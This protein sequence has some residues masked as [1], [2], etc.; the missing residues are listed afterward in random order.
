ME[1][2]KHEHCKAD[3]S[4]SGRE[5]QAQ[6]SSQPEGA[7]AWIA[8]LAQR[9]VE[10]N[11]D[12]GRNYDNSPD[13][14]ETAAIIA[15]AYAASRAQGTAVTTNYPAAISHS[16]TKDLLNSATAQLV[17]RSFCSRPCDQ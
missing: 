5:E 12:R 1:K 7:E 14:H 17:Q 15:E 16:T 9:I 2:C 11:N 4:T 10:A 6:Q 8:K 13:E 3:P